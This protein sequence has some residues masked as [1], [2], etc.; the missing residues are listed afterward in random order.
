VDTFYIGRM[1]NPLALAGVGAA[2]Q[3]FSSAFWIISFL[4][5]V[6]TPLVARAI[7]SGDKD[8]AA[9]RVCEALFVAIIIGALGTCLLTFGADFALSAVLDPKKSPAA[10]FA[11]P[12]LRV[13]ALTFI[14]ALFATTGFSAFRGLQDTVTPL[15]VS[16]FSNAL[17]VL[18]DPICMFQCGLGVTGA[19]LATGVAE[20]FSG[21]AYFRLLVRRNLVTWRRLITPPKLAQLQPLISGSFAVQARSIALNVGFLAATRRVQL[22]DASGVAAAAHTL[23]LQ[24][25]QLGGVI[26]LALSAAASALVP[27]ELGKDGTEGGRV[28]ADRL[29][30]TG[31]L[32][33]TVLAGLQLLALPLVDKLSVNPSVRSAARVPAILASL[34][35]VMNG[36]IF[37]GEGIMQGTTSFGGACAGQSRALRQPSL[38]WPTPAPR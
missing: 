33:G 35:Q 18:L 24:F 23:T 9:D 2:N 14:P 17:N 28:V 4:P 19:A 7:A 3:V 26:L 30:V 25:W 10:A 1:A 13:R 15:K 20:V 34:T 11:R 6:V 16:L 22:M 21:L 32:M 27:A 29:L 8:A 38:S 36:V 12:Y 31:L 5:S 37:A